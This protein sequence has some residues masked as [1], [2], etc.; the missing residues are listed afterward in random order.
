[1]SAVSDG[2]RTLTVK[3]FPYGTI[4]TVE[5][6]AIPQGAASA[7]QNWLSLGDRIE[8]R[9]G[10]ALLG[11]ENAGTGEIDNIGVAEKVDGTQ[12]LYR[13]NGRKL[14]YY[15]TATSDW[16]EVGTNIF[17]VAAENDYASFANYASLAGNQFF[18]CSPN[19]GPF[20]IMTANPG[21]YTDLT[22]ASKNFQGYIKIKQNRMFLWGRPKDK[23]GLYGSY[24]DAAAYTSVAG[25]VIAD[26]AAGTLAFKGAGAT[27]TCFAVTITDTSSGEVF[28]DNYDGTLT[29]SLGGTGTINYTTGAFTTSQSGAGTAT[30][31]WEDSNNTGITDFTKSSPRTAGQGFVFRQDDGGGALLNVFSYGDTEYCMH[32]TKTWALTLTATDTNATNLIYRDRVGIPSWQAGCETGNGIFYVDNADESDPQLRLL[33]L[34]RLSTEVIPVSIS[35]ARK[36]EA[37]HT[38]VGL[39]LTDYRFD[40]AVVREWGDYVLFA[41]RHKDSTKNDTLITYNKM[42]GALDKHSLSVS[43]LAIYNGTLV[44]GDSLSNNCYTLFSG[45]DDDDSLIN[46]SWEG[47]LSDLGTDYLKKIKKFIVQGRIQA[48]QSFDIYISID[49]GAYSLAGTIEGNGTYVDAG[50]PFLVGTETIGSHVVGSG[51]DGVNAFNFEH[52]ISLRTDKFQKIKLKFVATGIGYLAIMLYTWFDIRLY[53]K[54]ELTKYR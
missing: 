38:I 36:L 12:I 35:K 10:F 18:I 40:K 51:G 30:Y 21:S 37:E 22:N 44:C 11:T 46:N 26:T 27:R 43:S 2:L 34:S 39:N 50:N 7:S 33:T 53:A 24:I 13:K 14:E 1:M 6:Q 45:F 48:S 8:L 41:C 19:A 17:P 25:E 4:D 31:Q 54:K 52:I 16:V 23:T 9:R 42:T 47:A 15:N 28:T 3:S 49:N 20:K 5:D 29:G 32:E